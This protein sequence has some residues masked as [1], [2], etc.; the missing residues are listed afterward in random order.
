MIAAAQEISNRDRYTVDG[1]DALEARLRE[2]CDRVLREVRKVVPARKLE[3]LLL[4]G[5][6]GRGEGGVLHTPDGDL[7]YNDLDFYIFLRGQYFLNKVYDSGFHRLGDTISAN[8]GIEIEL[9]PDSLAR[10]RA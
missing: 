5:G 10:W 4:A 8:A 6:Y 1:S 2:L 7:P 9:K 3:G